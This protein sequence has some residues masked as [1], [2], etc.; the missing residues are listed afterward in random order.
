MFTFRLNWISMWRSWR[1]PLFLLLNCIQSNSK[2]LCR[3]LP[4]NDEP[5][6]TNKR[7]IKKKLSVMR[8]RFS[9]LGLWFTPIQIHLGWQKNPTSKLYHCSSNSIYRRKM[10]NWYLISVHIN[11]SCS[12]VIYAYGL[13]PPFF[14]KKKKNRIYVYCVGVRQQ[15]KQI[16]WGKLKN[17]KKAPIE[18]IKTI[19]K[20]QPA[21]RWRTTRACVSCTIYIWVHS[22]LT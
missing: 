20:Q 17:E 3:E 21:R 18:N 19:H 12:Y 7:W 5:N 2:R 22:L 6:T 8:F 10:H 13:Y 16:G 11:A 14:K 15:A 9:L 1:N 4:V